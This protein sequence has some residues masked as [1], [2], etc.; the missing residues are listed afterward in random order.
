MIC[1]FVMTMI[2]TVTKVERWHAFYSNR[3][4]WTAAWLDFSLNYVK[5]IL[6]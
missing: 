6:K 5:Q 1:F 2:A 4:G 3:D